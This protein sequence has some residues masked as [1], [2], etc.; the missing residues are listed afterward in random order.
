MREYDLAIALM[1]TA[2]VVLGLLLAALTR[3]ATAPDPLERIYARFCRRFSRI[4]LPRRASE[5]PVD[6]A[7]RVIA[8]RPDL[9]VAVESFISLYLPLRYAAG[10]R[11]QDYPELK[12]RLSRLRLARR[13]MSSTVK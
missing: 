2:G 4:G 3:P 10:D 13:D 1:V 8:A 12:R 7:K 6:Y 11:V 5:G 9:D